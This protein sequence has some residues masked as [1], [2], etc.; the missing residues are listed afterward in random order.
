MPGRETR[1]CMQGP[2]EGRPGS[3]T[4]PCAGHRRGGSEATAR[5]G[6]SLQAPA[7]RGHLITPSGNHRGSHKG[8]APSLTGCTGGGDP[9]GMQAAGGLGKGW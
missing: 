7:C 1:N 6:T 8:P 2:E 3:A 5:T 9:V 4:V